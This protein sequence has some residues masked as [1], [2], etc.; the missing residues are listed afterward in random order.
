MLQKIKRKEMR[1]AVAVILAVWLVG[2]QIFFSYLISI[3]EGKWVLWLIPLYM[4]F[5][6]RFLQYLKKTL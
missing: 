1:I 6:H 5:Y 2:S 4:F 3:H